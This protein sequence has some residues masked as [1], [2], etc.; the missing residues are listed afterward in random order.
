MADPFLGGDSLYAFVDRMTVDL[1]AEDTALNIARLVFVGT[2]RGGSVAVDDPTAVPDV[3]N[4]PP[5]RPGTRTREHGRPLIRTEIGGCELND[6]SA[7]GGVHAGTC[8]RG[9]GESFV[10]PWPVGFGRDSPVEATSSVDAL[11]AV[12]PKTV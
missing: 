9:A 4:D 1:T 5:Q 10:S 6:R 3:I 8:G 12:S 11:R 7:H 2:T